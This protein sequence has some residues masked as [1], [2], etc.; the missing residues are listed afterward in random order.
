MAGL[1][2]NTSVTSNPSATMRV[3]I[4]NRPMGWRLV[5]VLSDA[6]ETPR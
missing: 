1:L 3:R 6:S 2:A 5:F 4:P